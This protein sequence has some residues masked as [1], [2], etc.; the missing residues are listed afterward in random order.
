MKNRNLKSSRDKGT[1]IIPK[2]KVKKTI[3]N[4]RV[5]DIGKEIRK[6]TYGQCLILKRELDKRLAAVRKTE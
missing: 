2:L 4:E 1:K 6:F 5:D 3:T